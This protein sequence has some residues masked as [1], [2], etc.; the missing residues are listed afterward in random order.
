MKRDND[1]N[2]GK[3]GYHHGQMKKITYNIDSSSGLNML[4]KFRDLIK[5]TTTQK[6][7]KNFK[8]KCILYNINGHQPN[9]YV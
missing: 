8:N 9:T 7:M 2:D 6:S 1:T 5:K 4:W 3:H